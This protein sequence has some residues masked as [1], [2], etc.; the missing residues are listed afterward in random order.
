M[1]FLSLGQGCRGAQLQMVLASVAEGNTEA[2]TWAF[3]HP[4]DALLVLLW[5]KGNN[6]FYLLGAP[7]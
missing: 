1:E 4:E 3:A 6:V 7:P 5:D 2:Q